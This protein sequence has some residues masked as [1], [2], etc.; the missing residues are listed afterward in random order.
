MQKHT[1]VRR[2]AAAV[3]NVVCDQIN[4]LHAHY[5]YSNEIVENMLGVADVL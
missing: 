1:N 5:Y 3:H 4:R 2:Q